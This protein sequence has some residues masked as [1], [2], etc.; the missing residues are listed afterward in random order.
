[1]ADPL[2]RMKARRAERAAAMLAPGRSCEGCDVC[3]SAPGIADFDKPPGVPCKHLREVEPGRS[4]SIY[5]SR[6]RTCREFHCLWR[7][8][9]TVLPDWMRPAD[10]GFM[11]SFNRVDV[12]PGVVTVHPD[13]AR[14]KAWET[15]WHQSVFS[16]I[17][18]RWNCVVAIGQVPIT[19]HLFLPNGTRVSIAEHPELMGETTVGAPEFVFGPD[20]RPLREQMRE[21]VFEWGIKPPPVEGGAARAS[22]KAQ[23]AP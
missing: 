8:T 14:P 18:E 5:A 15:L 3:C 19:T 22:E 6:P 11:I 12:F 10:C 9:E 2:A 17:A 20:R 16:H 1:M 23:E 21:T 7:I 13:P 4:C